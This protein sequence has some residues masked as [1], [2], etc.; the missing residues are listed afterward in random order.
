MEKI[1]NT[2]ELKEMKKILKLIDPDQVFFKQTCEHV[3]KKEKMRKT[4]Q[5]RTNYGSKCQ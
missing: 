2:V 3:V 4:R 1:V 5:K